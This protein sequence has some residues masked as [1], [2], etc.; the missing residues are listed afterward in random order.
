MTLGMSPTWDAVVIA[1]T[2]GWGETSQGAAGAVAAALK[3]ASAT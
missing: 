3:V 1:Q 2:T